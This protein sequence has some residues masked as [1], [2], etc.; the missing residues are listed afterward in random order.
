MHSTS[1]IITVFIIDIHPIKVIILDNLH[2]L[3]SNLL[4][5]TKTVIPAVVHITSPT[6]SHPSS[7][8]RKDHLLPSIL[9]LLNQSWVGRVVANDRS[10]NVALS[11]TI[12]LPGCPSVGDGKCNHDMGVGSYLSCGWTRLPIAQVGN[13]SR[14]VSSHGSG[15]RWSWCR[16]HWWSRVWSGR[17]WRCRPIEDLRTRSCICVAIEARG[18]FSI[19]ASIASLTTL[20]VGIDP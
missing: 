9:P 20:R 16:G 1:Y 14:I 7:T 15:G 8:E 13:Q 10:S 6:S 2:E 5:F 18:A 17:W 12:V 19:G 4:F 3:R 11:I